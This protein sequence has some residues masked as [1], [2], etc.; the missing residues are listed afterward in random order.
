MVITIFTIALSLS[1][2]DMTN[3]LGNPTPY[4]TNTIHQTYTPYQ[5]NTT[6]PTYTPSVTPIGGGARIA[7][8]RSDNGRYQICLINVNDASIDC[9]TD[10]PVDSN[11]TWSPDGSHIAFFSIANEENSSNCGPICN[12]HIFVIDSDGENLTQIT[13]G[14]VHDSAPDWSPDGLI[15]AFSSNRDDPDP[16]NCQTDCNNEIYVM[17]EDGSH[18][19]R[20]TNDL[21]DDTNPAWSPDGKRITFSSWRSGNWQ[22]YV[23]NADGSQITKLTVGPDT[24]HSATWSPDGTKIMMTSENIDGPVSICLMNTDGAN[25]KCFSNERARHPVWSPDGKHIAFNSDNGNIYVMDIDGSHVRRITDF[26]IDYYT[27]SLDWEP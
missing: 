5:T 17:N 27:Y 15:I 21:A 6:F 20:L 22:I 16:S 10:G 8:T 7:F 11:P 23:M 13:Q 9:I 26:G 19:I 18:I 2:S 14:P 3:F 4:S 12:G 24:H 25:V 1:C